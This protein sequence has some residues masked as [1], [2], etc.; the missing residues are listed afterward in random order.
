MRL[1][2]RWAP[3]VGVLA[4]LAVGASGCSIDDSSGRLPSTPAPSP[5]V[6]PMSAAASADEIHGRFEPFSAE[7]IGETIIDLPEE[8]SVVSSGIVRMTYEGTSRLRLW[9]LDENH[10]EQM[11]FIDTTISLTSVDPARFDGE[12]SWWVANEP[13]HALRVEGDGAWQLSVVPVSDA[14]PLAGEGRGTRIYL[15]GG[16]GGTFPGRK[17]DT[18]VGMVITEIALT[19]RGGSLRD[20]VHR[21]RADH[22]FMVTLSPGPS[23]LV[24]THRGDWQLDLPVEEW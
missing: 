14:P 17:S 20:A 21:G 5:V 4:A 23:M 10:R 13:P 11:I 1:V 3:L 19:G 12:S 8:I 6:T 18:E 7:G 24:V 2:S 22:D 16:S 15:Y 9:S